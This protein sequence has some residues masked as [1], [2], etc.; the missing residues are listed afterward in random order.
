MTQVDN[1]ATTASANRLPVRRRDKRPALAALALL[2]VLAGALGSALIAYRSGQRTDVL[3]AARDIPVG[4][5]VTAAD[6]TTARV[7]SDSGLVSDASSKP[8]F[9]GTY[10]TTRVPRGTLINGKMF[11]AQGVTPDN[12]ELVGVVLPATQ[13]LSGIT[14]GSVVAAYYVP[15]KAGAGQDTPSSRAGTRILVS[16][17]VV[18]A[19]GAGTT[20]DGSTRLTLLVPTAKVSE[21]VSNAS[22]GTLAV[23]QLPEGTKPQVD[24]IGQ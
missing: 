22:A 12:A 5:K 17:R 19:S 20:S 21:V 2:L 16:A 4:H 24:L 11:Q 8:A 9:V 18:S 1:R 14:S 7:A 10:S 13:S 23:T 3:V 6:L 15:G